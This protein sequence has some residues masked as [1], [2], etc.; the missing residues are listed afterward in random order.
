VIK[1]ERKK[2]TDEFLKQFQAQLNSITEA[3][4]QIVPHLYSIDMSDKELRMIQGLIARSRAVVVRATGQDSEYNQ[5]IHLIL[6]AHEWD[7]N[8]LNKIIGVVESLALDIQ[9]GHLLSVTELIHGEIF[10][11]FLDMADHLSEKGYKDAAA[12]IAGSTLEAYV[13]HLYA[14]SK[15]PFELETSKGIQL[16]KA[17][18]TNSDLA[19][20]SG[21]SKIDLDNVTV[22]L[23]LRN[24]AAHG[25][26]DDYDKEQ[27]AVMINGVRDF[28]TRDSV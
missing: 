3:Y 27:V 25:K 24:K 1:Q 20:V 4:K 17:D 18:S 15:L 19:R 21:I 9:A 11:D 5:Q 13:L 10:G 12:I 6:A 23:D 14:K 28:V 26:Y 16:Y 2:V 22:W 8:T 7:T